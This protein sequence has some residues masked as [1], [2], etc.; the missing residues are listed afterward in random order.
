MKA[1]LNIPCD[2]MAVRHISHGL[3]QTDK[4]LSPDS[5]LVFDD[6]SP[7]WTGLITWPATYVR[8]MGS[9]LHYQVDPLQASNVGIPSV[10]L[11]VEPEACDIHL[12]FFDATKPHLY[13]QVHLCKATV[14]VTLGDG[15]IG[16]GVAL[17]PETISE[18]TGQ[19]VWTVRDVIVEGEVDFQ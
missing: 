6:G 2:P 17:L 4:L 18:R 7:T 13:M 19:G 1:K 9:V 11:D 16:R 10:I 14:T 8:Q 15:R 12:N 3:A 5:T